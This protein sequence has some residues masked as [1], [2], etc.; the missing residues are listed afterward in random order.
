LRRPTLPGKKFNH[1]EH[2]AMNENTANPPAAPVKPGYRTTE[3]WLTALTSV[4]A[5]AGT[6]SGVIPGTVGGILATVSTVAY[7]LSR[8]FVKR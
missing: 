8:A 6:L 4:S 3:F 1:T 7:A 2:K 5:V